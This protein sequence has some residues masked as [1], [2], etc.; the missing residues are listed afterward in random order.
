MKQKNYKYLYYLLI[1][2]VIGAIYTWPILVNFKSIIYAQTGDAFATIYNFWQLPYNALALSFPN[3]PVF[4]ALARL[5]RYLF[6]DTVTYNIFIFGSFIT[7]A[8]AG[9]L[10]T[11]K[12][13]KNDFAAF[14]G[15][16]I[17]VICPFR[18]S[19]SLQHTN[20][21]DLS[22]I[23]FFIL[24][25]IRTREKTNWFNILGVFLFF[26]LTTLINYQYG[27]FAGFIYIIYF[28]SGI[29]FSKNEERY[30]VLYS[31]APM[32][33]AVILILVCNKNMVY[34]YLSLTNGQATDFITARSFDELSTYSAKWYYY[35]LP[36]PQNPVFKSLTENIYSQTINELKTNLTEQSIYLGAINIILA[37]IAIFNIRKIDKFIASFAI[38]LII[39]GIYLSFSPSISF[40]G[41]NITTPS[42]LIYKYLPFFRVYARFGL[43][44][45]FGIVIFA[46]LGIYFI[47]EKIK[48]ITF[49]SIFKFLII[50]FVLVDLLIFPSNRI[51]SASYEAMGE[52][53]KVIQKL[54]KDDSVIAD[55]P[56]LPPEEPESYEYLFWQTFHNMPIY[57][58]HDDLKEENEF[59]KMA[60]NLNSSKT[61]ELLKERG[62]KYIIIHKD[63]YSSEKAKKYPIEYN[64]GIYPI[65][66]INNFYLIGQFGNDLVYKIK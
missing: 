17:L 54:N 55:Y 45:Y 61:L 60:S 15:G 18:I 7:T 49:K 12:I 3:Q 44:T 30:N 51:V 42:Q 8:I 48:N 40:L 6:S 24:F 4:S 14:F 59:I 27:F 29:I 58:N 19:Q 66:D 47:L 62:I 34:D 10:L 5:S 32:L 43:I 23:I 22:M 38:L 52:S 46:S 28:L 16:I 25:L 11:K 53:Y 20:F 41:I 31:V 39:V 50:I 9:F 63:K 26:S 56:L 37:I 35:F 64:N 2:I 21:A 57:Y 65:P 33:L 13:T 36:S 1:Y